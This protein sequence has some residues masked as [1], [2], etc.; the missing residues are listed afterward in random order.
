VGGF[1]LQST[2]LSIPRGCPCADEHTMAAASTFLDVLAKFARPKK[3]LQSGW[4]WENSEKFGA[5]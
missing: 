1:F 2:F 5:S 3:Q 4:W